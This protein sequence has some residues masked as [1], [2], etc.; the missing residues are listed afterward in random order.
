MEDF[1]KIDSY[2]EDTT[3]NA[4]TKKDKLFRR[5][6]ITWNNPFW[7]NQFEE[8]DIN[9]TDL[10]LNLEKYDYTYF[11]EED[12]IECFDFKSIKY[13]NKKKNEYERVERAFFKDDTAIQNYFATLT[14]MKYYVFQIIT[15]YN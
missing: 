15:A 7:E 13:F 11:K 10:P 14:N 4:D 2:I 9:N 6:F 5:F 3:K 1:A 12:A 8:V